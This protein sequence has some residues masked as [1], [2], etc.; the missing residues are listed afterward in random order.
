MS[1]TITVKQTKSL[2]G[3]PV[4]VR[5]V[6]L[7]LGLGRV[8]KVK[9]HKDNNCIRGMINKVKHLVSYQVESK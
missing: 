5:K 3:N 8:G 4:K 7:G 9:V 6:V 2:I 1:G